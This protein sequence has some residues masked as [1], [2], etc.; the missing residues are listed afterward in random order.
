MR[1]EEEDAAAND[2]GDDDGRRIERTKAAFER[3]LGGC[4]WSAWSLGQ[5]LSLDWKLGEFSPDP[6]SLLQ[7]YFDFRVHEL[8]VLQHLQPRLFAGIAETRT[9]HEIAR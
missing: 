7:K 8:L 6:R 9:E 3:L 5:E 1:G 2:V 4:V